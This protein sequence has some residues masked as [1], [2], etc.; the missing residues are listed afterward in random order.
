MPTALILPNTTSPIDAKIIELSKKEVESIFR[1]N[2][3]SKETITE[4]SSVEPKAQLVED[5]GRET[6]LYILIGALVGSFVLIT[7][8]IVILIVLSRK[9]RIKKEK[10]NLEV[11]VFILEIKYFYEV[12]ICTKTPTCTVVLIC[13]EEIFIYFFYRT[14]EESVKELFLVMAENLLY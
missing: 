11:C 8:L 3:F 2:Q 12:N 14:R 7:L 5:G 9:R 4:A 10:E 13:S 6:N 1:T